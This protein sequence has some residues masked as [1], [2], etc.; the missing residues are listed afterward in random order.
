M[1]SRRNFLKGIG[2]TSLVTCLPNLAFA[3]TDSPNVFIWVTLRGAMD[4]LNVVVPTFDTAY[5]TLRPTLAF[6]ANELLSLEGGY[7]LNPA[8]NNVFE[9][10][11][12]DQAMF[13]H[14]CATG[15]RSRSHF[16]G[17]KVL[18]N[19]TVNPLEREG[20]LNR[21]LM[22]E[23]RNLAIA[24]DSGLP[25]IAQGEM[26]VSSWYPHKLKAKEEQAMILADLFQSDPE[27]GSN[28][29]EAMKLEKML[30]SASQSKQF[31]NLMTQAGKFINTPQG[32][33]IA[34]LELGG[35]D[36]HSAQG[37]TQGRL[38]NQ[39]KKLDE[40]LLALKSALGDKWASTV[41]MCA[42]EFGRTARENG[43]KG[44]DHG[45]ANVMLL[46]GGAIKKGQVV[47]D[48][49]GLGEAQLFEG[50]D[51]APTT[52]TRSVIK[53]VLADHYLADSATL[54]NVFPDSEAI[55]PMTGLIATKQA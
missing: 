39:L 1:T 54:L 29:S 42:S 15:Y 50:R 30:G 26:K 4:G 38:A 35:W 41:V 44:T 23:K 55:T 14:A 13:V 48:W 28:F 20:W 43:T 2:A 12:N 3:T 27:L 7:G 25:L 51:L 11:Q 24:I 37:T 49:P 36:T 19:G 22:T 53:G 5:S 40:G 6:D 34:V 17:Q 21:F 18:E 45:T 10:Y 33:N 52:D 9:W 31:S 47:S 46:A 16:D 32:P 8:L